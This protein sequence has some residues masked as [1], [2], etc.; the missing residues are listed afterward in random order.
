MAYIAE[1]KAYF[2]DLDGTLTDSRAGLYPAFRSGLEAIG[3]PSVSDERLKLFLGTP[4]PQLFREMRS[5]VGQREIDAGI[6]AFRSTFEQTGI[7]ANELYPGIITMLEAVHRHRA[8]IWVVTSKPEFQAVRVVTHLGLD[9]FVA[10]VVGAGLAETDTKADLVARALSA[11]QVA[12]HEAVMV[13]DRSY[14]VAGALANR[15]LPIGALWGYGS[16]D[17]LKT[18]GCLH[19]ARTPDEFR[20]V[21]VEASPSLFAQRPLSAT[22]SR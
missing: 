5:D 3:I 10:G 15:V 8:K 19:F 20:E 1:M 11:A 18:A 2:F 13:G 21:F 4:L 17:E 22:A 7:I 16:E 6:A 9:R 12:S 14:D